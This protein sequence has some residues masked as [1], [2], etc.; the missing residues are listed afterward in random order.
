[1]SPPFLH[2]TV[3]AHGTAEE[4]PVEGAFTLK[5]EVP[6]A[7][8]LRAA[9]MTL[10]ADQVRWR[11]DLRLAG[12]SLKG[13]I[14]IFRHGNGAPS[15]DA[16]LRCPELLDGLGALT[17]AVTAEL[18]RLDARAP[19]GTHDEALRSWRA[20]RL[21]LALGRDEE[22]AAEAKRAALALGGAADG[23]PLR[24]P[25]RDPH[26]RAL[27]GELAAMLENAGRPE[28]AARIR[29]LLG[30]PDGDR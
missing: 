4:T 20:A 7:G 29:S 6:D 23:E 21:L 2:G 12:R 30:G 27:G 26:L 16:R 18:K 22:G 19:G 9:A 5:H 13:D 24:G 10:Q 8:I 11:V 3:T 25:L 17:R 28:G 15:M 1:M 14:R